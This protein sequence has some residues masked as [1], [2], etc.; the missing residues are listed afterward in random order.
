MST[1]TSPLK[2]EGSYDLL[3]RIVKTVDDL[4]NAI[5]ADKP[6]PN[7]CSKHLKRLKVLIPLLDGE[8]KDFRAQQKS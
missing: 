5:R 2:L 4:N 8:I 7:E 1:K 3:T 6:V